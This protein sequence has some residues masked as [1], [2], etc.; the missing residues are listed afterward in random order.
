[1][2]S[3]LKT[4]ES[5]RL[6]RSRVRYHSVIFDDFDRHG[7]VYTCPRCGW[8]SPGMKWPEGAIHHGMKHDLECR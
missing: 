5:R 1:M 8:K 7:E 4:N 6:W 2:A 3:V